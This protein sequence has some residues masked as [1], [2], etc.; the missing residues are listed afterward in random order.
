VTAQ[1]AEPSE[2]PYPPQAAH[3]ILRAPDGQESVVV[4]A[5]EFR[6]LRRRAQDAEALAAIARNGTTPPPGARLYSREE[7]EELWGSGDR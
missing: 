2:D 1:P 6:R 4:P 5:A 7:L 3:A